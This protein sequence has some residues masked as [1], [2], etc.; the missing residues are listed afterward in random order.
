MELS[1]LVV[2]NGKLYTV[3]DRTGIVFELADGKAIPWTILA[4]G[5]GRENGGKVH[6]T[7][8]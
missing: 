1:E 7:V 4:D 5:S 8:M 2:Y 6:K 3:D